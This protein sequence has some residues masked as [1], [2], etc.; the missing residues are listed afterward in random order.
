MKHVIFVQQIVASSESQSFDLFPYRYYIGN[1]I[2]KSPNLVG[3]KSQVSCVIPAAL[4]NMIKWHVYVFAETI[5]QETRLTV[6]QLSLIGNW[7]GLLKK[8]GSTL[9]LITVIEI[10]WKFKYSDFFIKCEANV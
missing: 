3:K 9:W 4:Y 2:Q 5:L 6:Y 8:D 7:A 1:A 10:F